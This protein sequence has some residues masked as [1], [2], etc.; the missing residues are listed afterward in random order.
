MEPRALYPPLIPFTILDVHSERMVCLGG[1]D[2]PGPIC[3][4]REERNPHARQRELREGLTW[5]VS[6]ARRQTHQRQR[7]EAS[8]R[9]G[10]TAVRLIYATLSQQRLCRGR[11]IH[12]VTP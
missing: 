6:R 3:R 12:H 11:P 10:D 4:S 9:A 2:R 1:R 5:L 7:H 8:L